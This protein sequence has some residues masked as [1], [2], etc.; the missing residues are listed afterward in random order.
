[1]CNLCGTGWSVYSSAFFMEP[2]TLN[3]Q[4]PNPSAIHLPLQ[5]VCIRVHLCPSLPALLRQGQNFT[6]P[7]QNI[8]AYICASSG[9]ILFPSDVTS[10]SNS[11]STKPI[12]QPLKQP[13]YLHALSL[14]LCCTSRAIEWKP[15]S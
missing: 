14:P 2:L 3:V 11:H 13:K 4:N 8:T 9:G 12:F 5:K 10:A 1:M 15:L 7:F 6:H